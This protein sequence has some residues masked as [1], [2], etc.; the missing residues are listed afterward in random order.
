[1]KRWFIVGWVALGVIAVAWVLIIRFSS[2]AWAVEN[3]PR[4]PESQTW[5][6]RLAQAQLTQM[7][8]L[9]GVPSTWGDPT[10]PVEGATFVL[11]TVDVTNRVEGLLC[12][13]SLIGDG[14]EWYMAVSAASNIDESYLTSCPGDDVPSTQTITL[15][16]IFEVPTSLLDEL[17]GVHLGVAQ[18]SDK[19]TFLD[20]NRPQEEAVLTGVLSGR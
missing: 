3:L 8:V 11:V 19:D 10:L 1:M 13:L 4:V 2:A 7:M 6:T 9:E 15:G 5:D 14:R 18:A 16:R 17:E 20:F 12:D